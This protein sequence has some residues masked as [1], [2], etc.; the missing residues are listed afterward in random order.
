MSWLTALESFAKKIVEARLSTVHTSLP[1]QIVSYDSALNTCSIQP[2]IMRYDSENIETGVMSL[3][4]LDDIPVQQSGSGKLL[5]S[6]AP[7][8]GSYGNYI[9][10]ES[11]LS[12][13][14]LEGG[15][16]NP[17]NIEKHNLNDGV[18]VPGLYPF[19]A[20]GDNGKLQSPI[21]TDRI[22]LR[23]RD[24]NTEISVLDDGSVKITA[25]TIHINGSSE[26]A[27]LGNKFM[28]KYNA[29]THPTAFGPSGPP[30]APWTTA[31]LSTTVKIG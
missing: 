26:P 15:I 5:L 7:Q 19:K 23:T 30:I 22:S 4:Q 21:A 10:S 9:V 25:T 12:N 16:S 20:D 1:A 17:H 8:T 2:V 28:T 13:W 29:H 3:P 27:M 24:G 11:D 14:L 6:V 31:D 18:F